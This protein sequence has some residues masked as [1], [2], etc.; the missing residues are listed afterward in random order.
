M[1]LKLKND[2]VFKAFFAKKGNERFLKSFLESLLK[3]KIDNIKIQGEVSLLQMNKEDKLGRLELKATINQRKVIDIEIQL[4]DR[5]NTEKRSVYYGAKLVTE[6]I[7]KGGEYIETKP[8]ILINILNYNLLDVP[9]YYTKTVTVAELHRDYEVIKD[10]TYYF[11]ELPKF[12]KSKP[13]LANLLEC[14][15]ALIDGENRGLIEMAESKNEIIKEANEEVEEI[16]SESQIKELNDYLFTARLERNS[17][18]GNA[19]REGIEKGIKRANTK[20]VKRLYEK[21]ISIEQIIEITEL[22]EEEIRKIIKQ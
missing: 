16:L 19:M 20:I 21:N 10:A 13:K 1:E 6:Q 14:W 8:V 22:T 15:L 9:E 2:I 12:R 17:I 3:E 18:K 11:I 4:E 5:K 7:G